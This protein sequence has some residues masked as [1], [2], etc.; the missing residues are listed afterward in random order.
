MTT[1][2][3]GSL[4]FDYLQPCPSELVVPKESH[5]VSLVERNSQKG[6]NTMLVAQELEKSGI[7]S[8]EPVRVR[9]CPQT[10]LPIATD[11]YN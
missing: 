10:N 4:T 1:L 3:E 7:G 6:G 5:L 8:P 11:R 2:L 9:T